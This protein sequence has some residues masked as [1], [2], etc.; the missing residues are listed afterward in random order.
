[1]VIEL[2]VIGKTDSR[3]VAALVD[4]YAR[5][6]NFYCRFAVTTLPDVRNTRKLSPAQQR[7]A[8]GEAILRQLSEGDFVA[9]L[10]ERGTEYRSVEFAQ[11]LQK[12]LNSGIKRLVLVIGGPYG[13][14]E[15]VYGRADARLSLSRMTFSHQIV[16]AIFAEQIYRAFT[17]L[18]NEPYHHE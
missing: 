4:M 14:S 8:E 16:R 12:R 13:F 7:T 15:E 10:D 18:H 2:I 6:V 11:W 3:E 9:L 1:M 17:I 5:R